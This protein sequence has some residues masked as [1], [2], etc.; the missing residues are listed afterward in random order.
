[1]LLELRR[2]DDATSERA[3]ALAS[4]KA[5]EIEGRIDALQSNLEAL[6]RLLSACREHS[7]VPVRDSP[8]FEALANANPDANADAKP[9]ARRA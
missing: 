6:R 5:A 2:S 9:E 7:H 3:I 8:I 4:D 1:M